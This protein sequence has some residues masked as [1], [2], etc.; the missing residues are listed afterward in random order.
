MNKA[1]C[2]AAYV[3]R[4][5]APQIKQVAGIVTRHDIETAPLREG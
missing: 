1:N 5:P 2:D 3:W 4:M